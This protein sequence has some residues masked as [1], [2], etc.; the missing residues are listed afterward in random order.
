MVEGQFGPTG[1]GYRNW[2]LLMSLVLIA[3]YRPSL[4]NNI[5]CV[6]EITGLRVKLGDNPGSDSGCVQVSDASEI[7]V[8]FECRMFRGYP[9]PDSWYRRMLGSTNW[10]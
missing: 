3:F 10:L 2:E 6:P 5:P 8:V 4:C 7:V 1:I 9:A